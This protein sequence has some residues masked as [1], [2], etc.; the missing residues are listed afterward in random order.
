[1]ALPIHFF[2][3]FCCRMYRL[4]TIAVGCIGQ[5][6]NTKKTEPPKFPRL[7]WSWAAWWFYFYY[8]MFDRLCSQINDDD[9]DDDDD[10]HFMRHFWWFD[11]QLYR[12]S[13]AVRS[14]FLATAELFVWLCYCQTVFEL[15]GYWLLNYKNTLFIGTLGRYRGTGAW[16]NLV[17]RSTMH[18]NRSNFSASIFVASPWRYCKVWCLRHDFLCRC[19]STTVSDS[20]MK[21]IRPNASSKFTSHNIVDRTK[22]I[23]KSMLLHWSRC[24]Y[25]C[26]FYDAILYN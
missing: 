22:T 17:G 1:M 5:P 11:L 14:A 19:Q 21:M 4:D 13:Y 25:L 26:W 16:E 9:D 15:T 2:R 24:C 10:S 7:E 23:G 3:H 8:F 6:Q 20:V 12:T 18:L